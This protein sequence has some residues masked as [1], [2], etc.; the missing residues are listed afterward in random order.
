MFCVVSCKRM[1]SQRHGTQAS[2]MAKMIRY[3]LALCALALGLRTDGQMLTSQYDNA[4]SGTNL[5]ET[6]LTPRN[7]N[8]QLLGKFFTL[9]VDG[10]IYAQPLFLR[11]VEIPG[12]GRHDVLF[13]ATEHD[14]VY[15]FDAYGNPKS[16]LWQ[17]SFLRD[18]ITTVPARDA[19]CPFISPEIGIT[20][21]PVIDPRAGT[22]YVL[23]R[24]KDS[25]GR[26]FQRLHA[27]AVT[28]GSEKFGGPAEI[29]ASVSGSG[30]GSSDG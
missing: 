28:T 5:N 11:G 6:N 22:L 9:S 4:R 3:A 23:A 15:A 21:T 27:L 8:R 10:D 14:S 7:V 17:V 25:S 20:S 13:I 12:K 18:G 26:Y 24:T 2:G 1:E 19:D 16:P 30:R 29:Q